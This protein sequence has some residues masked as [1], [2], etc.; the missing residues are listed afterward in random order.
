MEIPKCAE[1][2][3]NIPLFDQYAHD[4]T[5]VE[6]VVR[7]RLDPS[8]VSGRIACRGPRDYKSMDCTF[9]AAELTPTSVP[10]DQ[11]IDFEGLLDSVEIVVAKT[12][13]DIPG[14]RPIC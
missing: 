2:C 11:I 8:I 9:C 14:Y 6:K 7:A 5:I 3:R 13:R 12:V 4:V 1:R 10:E